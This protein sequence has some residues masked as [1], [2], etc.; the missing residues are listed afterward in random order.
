MIHRVVRPSPP[1]SFRSS[2]HPKRKLS[3]SLAHGPH[4]S[5]F[6]LWIPCS[7]HFLSMESHTIGPFVSASLTE[8]RVHKAPPCCDVDQSPI[9]SYW[10]LCGRDSKA[11]F[12]RFGL[13]YPFISDSMFFLILAGWWMIMGRAVPTPPSQ[14]CRRLLSLSCTCDCSP[15]LVPCSLSFPWGLWRPVYGLI[16]RP[17]GKGAWL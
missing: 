17:T 7:G 4:K 9:P 8:H 1:S 12:P 10:Q 2:Y 6:Y 3:P 15:L 14:G 5:T 16:L 13:P 11:C